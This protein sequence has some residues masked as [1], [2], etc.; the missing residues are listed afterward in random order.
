MDLQRHHLLSLTFVLS[1]IIPA[2]FIF[3]FYA[4]ENLL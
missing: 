1:P 2:A 4:F 3:S